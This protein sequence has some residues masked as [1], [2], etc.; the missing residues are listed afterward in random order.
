MSLDNI[1]FK[2]IM[3]ELQIMPDSAHVLV[4]VSGG[5]DSVVLL[6]LL[7][8]ANYI[9]TVAHVNY[10]LRGKESDGDEMFV[11]RLCEKLNY[12]CRV[13]KIDPDLVF[14]KDKK[15]IQDT[16]RSIRYNW[17]DEILH[18][19]SAHKLLVAHHRNDQTETIIHQFVRGGV[20]KSLLGMSIQSGNVCRPLLRFSKEEI[21]AYAKAHDLNWRT[22]SSNLSTDYTRNLIR[23]EVIPIF[24]KVNPGLHKTIEFRTEVLSEV[25]SIIEE[26]LN[27][28]LQKIIEFSGASQSLDLERFMTYKYPRLLLWHWLEPAGFSSAQMED[29]MRLVFSQSGKRI[30]SA[31]HVLWKEAERLVLTAMS[32]QSEVFIVLND[33]FNE[34]VELGLSISR[35][36]RDKVFFD[37]TN[38]VQF[39]DLDKIEMP[40]ILRTWRHG[41][42]F[43]PLG[44]KQE[45]K[46]SDFLIHEKVPLRLKNEVLVLE[47]QGEI[48][49]IV[50]FRISD[51]F[52]VS[53][54][55]QS[56]L[57]IARMLL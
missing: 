18:E 53:S 29:V 12:D 9:V 25:N 45:K 11:R 2:L 1:S 44:M 51:K 5:L 31:S 16:A 33:P 48:I 7:H 42:T 3:Q 41:D 47:N 55:T 35:E 38:N 32:T 24:E 37:K 20:L 40:V 56:V 54:Q 39:I 46:V 22:D 14:G 4:A 50:G 26:K 36:E 43:V 23:H 27:E 49:A 17:F 28:D 8:E 57:R 10:G 19:I 13:L 34:A 15:S 6:N 30:E 52:K 21:L